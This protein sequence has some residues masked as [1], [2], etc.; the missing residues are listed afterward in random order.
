MIEAVFDG[1]HVRSGAVIGAYQYDTG[2]R[3]VMH[4]LPS[5]QELAGRDELLSGDLVTM[6]AQFSYRGDS[7]TEMRLAMWDGKRR[8]WLVDVPDDYLT[9]HKDV[10]VYV[11]CYYGANENGERA[12][13]VYEATFRPISR[14]A[15][16]GMV[17]EEQLVQWAEL[18]A[19]IEISMAKV[20]SAVDGANSAAAEAD[21]AGKHAQ[22]QAA[23]ADSA[24]KNA[25]EAMDEL[26]RAGNRVGCA[27]G[28]TQERP[29]GSEA[30]AE[31]ELSGNTGTLT[32][33]APAGTEGK[34]GET[35]DRGPADVTFEFDGETGTLSVTTR[36][37][38]GEE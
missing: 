33:G 34:K 20:Q 27:N 12:E 16:A 26:T 25:R 19:E 24:A 5:P 2:Q 36:T 1:G 15:P 28:V 31:L 6:Q 13:T 38:T 18:K 4:G 23:D 10:Q 22:Q 30:T 9:R 17:T 32:I 37:D 7:Q 3:L 29:V 11:F 14:P 8:V 35:G 21:A